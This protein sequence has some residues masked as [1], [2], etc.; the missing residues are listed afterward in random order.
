MSEPALS[1][2]TR[3]WRCASHATWPCARLAAVCFGRASANGFG[4]IFRRGKFW[5]TT[6]TARPSFADGFIH[7]NRRTVTHD[8]SRKQFFGKILGFFAAAGLSTK[9][10]AKSAP[11]ASSPASV[12]V[13]RPES[14]A[15]P[16]A[17]ASL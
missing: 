9:L 15:V 12:I 10:L 1:A 3:F 8:P 4:E 5:F 16:R 13:A 11:A 14:R 2:V 6:E 7:F 17:G